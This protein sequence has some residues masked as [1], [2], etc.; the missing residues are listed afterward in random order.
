MILKQEEKT[1]IAIGNIQQ[2]TVGIDAKNVNFI[3][4]LLT[5]KLYS[6]PIQSFLREI[7]SNAYDSHIEANSSEP[8]L[9]NLSYDNNH[10]IVVSVRDYGTGLSPERFN[11][12]YKNIGSSS[13]RES[14]DYIGCLGIGRFSCLAVSNRCTIVSYYEGVKDTYL[15]YKDEGTVHIDKMSSVATTEHNGIEVS[16][17]IENSYNSKRDLLE[18]IENL[19]YFPNIYVHNQ[20]VIQLRDG[21]NKRKV[22]KAK[23]FNAIVYQTLDTTFDFEEL[24]TYYEYTV[25]Y[26]NVVYPLKL[27]TILPN[28]YLPK[29]RDLC[30]KFDIGELDVTPSRE[31]LQMTN[32]TMLAIINKLQAYD[33]ELNSILQ[34]EI[35]P[36]NS[37]GKILDYFANN[38]HYCN[39]V[40]VKF[41]ISPDLNTFAEIPIDLFRFLLFSNKNNIVIKEGNKSINITGN[42]IV[43]ILD[44]IMDYR[45]DIPFEH[46]I[47]TRYRKVLY[48]QDAIQTKEFIRSVANNE[49]FV[50]NSD[51]ILNIVSQ[52]V[53]EKGLKHYF[54]TSKKWEKEFLGSNFIN[55]KR[56]QLEKE[57]L[58]K[59]EVDVILRSFI[60]WYYSKRILLSKN[61]LPKTYVIS[62][63]AAHKKT[64]KEKKELTKED[65]AF[66][67]FNDYRQSFIRIDKSVITKLKKTNNIYVFDKESASI[68]LVLQ[69]FRGYRDIEYRNE[70]LSF[71]KMNI[72]ICAVSKRNLPYCQSM[73]LLTEIDFMSC[74]NPIFKR[75]AAIELWKKNLNIVKDENLIS[76]Y[77]NQAW[78][79]RKCIS[80]DRISDIQSCYR[81]VIS[82]F[83]S[84]DSTLSEIVNKCIENNFVNWS[85][86]AKLPTFDELKVLRIAS[87]SI[88]SSRNDDINKDL[89]MLILMKK[90]II[91]FNVRLYHKSKIK[92]NECIEG[93]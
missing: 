61:T 27:T 7:V 33:Y 11:L 78:K 81:D 62:W 52:F 45:D 80:E 5:E 54:L 17:V 41:N 12:I 72:C 53:K 34:N 59:E 16:V 58:S 3:T 73:G 31:S 30:L 89:L 46:K 55:Q 91:P 38:D 47:K 77:I 76:D 74:E 8:I 66:W 88:L 35:Y 21:F 26:G 28:V 43:S 69:M 51:K 63:N 25:L 60:R 6:K 18:G 67:G 13:K 1:A 84:R 50:S 57:K 4:S 90:K 20:G 83:S 19:A 49:V 93:W 37:I 42:S 68:P 75:I 44:I 23:N 79:C 64:P 2:N 85:F 56:L 71:P 82:Y 92:V 29:G 22:V 87:K 39:L 40:K 24:S 70:M 36:I 86:Y 9:I 65:I 15:M 32:K 10:Y 14:D 48:K